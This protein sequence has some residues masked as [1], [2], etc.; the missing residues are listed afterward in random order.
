MAAIAADGNVGERSVNND[1][2]PGF[3][4]CEWRIDNFVVVVAVMTAPMM[5]VVILVVLPVI[6]NFDGCRGGGRCSAKS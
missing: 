1:A 3:N 4:M 2:M 5:V 6:M